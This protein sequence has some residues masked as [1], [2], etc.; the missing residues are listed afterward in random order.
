VAVALVL[1]AGG[2]GAQ[3]AV[4]LGGQL[5]WRTEGWTAFNE[6]PGQ[7]DTFS[8]LRAFGHADIT[9]GDHLRVFLQGRSSLAWDRTLP[10]GRRTSDV[11]T[12]DI[13]NTWVELRGGT[14]RYVVQARAGR[15]ELSYGRQR[16]VSP[17]NWSNTRRIFDGV[18]ASLASPDDS[19]T[20]EG[21]WFRPVQVRKYGFNRWIP[22]QRLAGVYATV[23]R[24]PAD[25]DLY[26]LSSRTA[27]GGPDARQTAGARLAIEAGGLTG[28][29]EAAWQWGRDAR[30][31]MASVAPRYTWA[32]A[33]APWIGAGADYATGDADPSDGTDGT[34]DP[35]FPL[36]HSWLG[37][38]DAVGRRNIVSVWVPVGFWPVPDRVSLGADLHWFR[39]AEGTDALYDSGRRVSRPASGQTDVGR[40]VDVTLTI[41]VDP[42]TE[43]TFGFNRLEPGAVFGPGAAAAR[44]IYVQVEREF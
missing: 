13:W 32:T 16:L 21:L 10:G 7:D 18:R 20:V 1:G 11:D 44:M 15:Q 9:V 30:A 6:T 39:L 35:I 24:G 17:I 23:R 4:E 19:W 25:V 36:G 43:L 38:I 33:R 27:A 42:R 34:F 41:A 14:G 28:D 31:W 37:Y 8:L 3:T 2:V 22:D 12:I 5:R 29:A 26:L 40:E